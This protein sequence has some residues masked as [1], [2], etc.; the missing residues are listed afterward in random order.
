MRSIDLIQEMPQ[1]DREKIGM[2][3]E[4]MT[5][6]YITLFG[7][8]RSGNSSANETRLKFIIYSNDILEQE[9]EDQTEAKIG[10]VELFVED[11]TAEIV[12]VRGANTAL[13]QAIIRTFPFE[14]IRRQSPVGARVH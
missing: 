11:G 9:P 2:G 10:V 5:G 13:P 12:G 6:K 3:L 4:T 1:L 7:G 14:Q 8:M